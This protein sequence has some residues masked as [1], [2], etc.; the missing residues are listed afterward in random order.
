MNKILSLEGLRGYAALVVLFYHSILL[1]VP[2]TFEPLLYGTY[3]E[4]TSVDQAIGKTV[5]ALLDGQFAV[6]IFFILSGMVLLESGNK[7]PFSFKMM[8]SFTLK[9]V[10]RIYPAAIIVIAALGAVFSLTHHYFPAIYPID[11]EWM[12]TLK[13][14]ALT[15]IITHGASWT[16]KVEILMIPFL[17]IA[18][19]C[20]KKAGIYGLLFFLG[21]ALMA[22]QFPALTFNW[23]YMKASLFAFGLGFLI[24]CKEIAPYFKKVGAYWPLFL[25]VGLFLSHFIPNAHKITTLAQYILAFMLVGALTHCSF[26]SSRVIFENKFAQFLGKISYSLYL[27][28]VIFLSVLNPILAYYFPEWVQNHYVLSGVAMGILN[29]VLT[30]PLSVL[31]YRYVEVPFIQKGRVWAQ[32]LAQFSCKPPYLLVGSTFFERVRLTLTK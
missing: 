19:F 7:E 28:N 20:K 6:L 27:I 26:K 9:R 3:Y 11:L 16:L 29:F 14:M 30:V 15:D 1:Y 12:A 25:I 23:S 13:N 4:L 32:K 2:N 31:V 22:L 8:L 5:L 10:C 18:I 21:Y 24:P 17:L